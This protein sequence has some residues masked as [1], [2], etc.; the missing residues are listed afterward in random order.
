MSPVRGSVKGLTDVVLLTATLLL[1]ACREEVVHGIDE[2][3]ANRIVAALANLEIDATKKRES[4]GGWTILVNQRDSSRV[5]RT[6]SER[7]LLPIERSPSDA[8]DGML[9]SREGQS[10]RLERRMSAGIEDTLRSVRGILDARVHLNLGVQRDLF[11]PRLPVG[12]GKS[13]SVLLIVTPE[14]NVPL[15]DI[16]A[17]VGQASGIH[18]KAVAVVHSIEGATLPLQE[19]GLGSSRP[20]DRYDWTVVQQIT[21]FGLTPLC[22]I[23]CS[24]WWIR[25]RRPAY[26]LP[27]SP[28]LVSSEQ[29]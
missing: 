12:D 11:D 16:A 29:S 6:L 28:P 19:I 27:V 22:L 26:R 20:I 17:L 18:P 15:I 14:Y 7:R 3:R 4:D 1:G 5:I 24:M 2:S 9:P 21:L 13:G 8:G 23:G 10:F 25:R